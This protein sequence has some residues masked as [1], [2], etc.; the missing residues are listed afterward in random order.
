MRSASRYIHTCWTASVALAMLACGTALANHPRQQEVEAG[1]NS[2]GY[3]TICN[4]TSFD[5]YVAYTDSESD[6]RTVG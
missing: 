6:V 5:I 2:H 1:G 4:D 3:V